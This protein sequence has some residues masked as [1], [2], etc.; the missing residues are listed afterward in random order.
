MVV[1]T[2]KTA[3]MDWIN[4]SLAVIHFC[5]IPPRMTV[6][7]GVVFVCGGAWL[8]THVGCRHTPL[9]QSRLSYWS[10]AMCYN[11]CNYIVGKQTVTIETSK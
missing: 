4:T 1:A 6:R 3:C 11:A 7:G 5:K 9:W 2:C 8:Y 10:K